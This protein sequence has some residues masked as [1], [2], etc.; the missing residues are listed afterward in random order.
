MGATRN[1]MQQSVNKE[2]QTMTMNS[3]PLEQAGDRNDSAGED[4]RE[5]FEEPILE[6]QESLTKITKTEDLPGG[7][8]SG[9]VF[10]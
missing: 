2:A 5:P 1:C 4:R 7:G 6:K 8:I 3:S 9:A 10:F